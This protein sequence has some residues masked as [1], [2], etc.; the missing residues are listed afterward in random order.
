M[1]KA[2][3]FSISFKRR[4]C[5]TEQRPK[6]RKDLRCLVYLPTASP[7]SPVVTLLL[8]HI[9]RCGRLV[10]TTSAMCGPR[11][12][13]DS[14][15]RAPDCWTRPCSRCCAGFAREENISYLCNFVSI[16]WFD[17]VAVYQFAINSI[18]SSVFVP[19]ETIVGHEGDHSD[20]MQRWNVIR[21]NTW[22]LWCF[23]FFFAS[24][25]PLTCCLII[26]RL[27]SEKKILIKIRIQKRQNNK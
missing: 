6:G 14:S 22:F 5:T 9:K 26:I 18:K 2:L 27:K 4:R 15:S 19:V 3:L 1:G 25:D 13:D 12:P 23:F 10:V 21:M 7:R 11:K 17:I 16:Y 8:A 24:T 20:I